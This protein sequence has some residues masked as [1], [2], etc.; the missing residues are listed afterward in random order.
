MSVPNLLWTSDKFVPVPDNLMEQ[1]V[2]KLNLM[3][4]CKRVHTNGGSAGI[5]GMKTDRL[6][7]WLQRNIE[8]LQNSLLEGSYQPQPVRAVGIEKPGGGKRILSIPTVVDRLIQQAI[9]QVLNPYFDPEFSSFSYGFR[10]GRSTKDAVLWVQKYQQEGK[11]WVIDVDLSKFFDEVN[12]DVLMSLIKRKVKDVRLLKLIDKY[13]RTGI[14]HG[15]VASP[16]SKG[17]PQGS[18]LSP[19]LSNILLNELDKEL[20]KRGHSFCRYADDFVIL[21]RSRKSA[22]R[23]FTSITRFIEKRLKLKINQTKSRVIKGYQLI[24]LG[25]GFTSDRN[26]RLTVPKSIRQRFRMKARELFRKGKGMNIQKFIV[27]ILNPFIRGWINYYKQSNVKG[28]AEELDGWI[29][30]RLRLII[31]RQWKKPRTRFRRFTT[32]GYKYVHA[33]KC[34]YNGRGAWWNSGAQHMQFCFPKKYFDR[35]GL[36]SMLYLIVR[37]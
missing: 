13:F 10:K 23:V 2:D 12:H 17:T 31:W 25:Y 11:R 33:M 15:G 7:S 20:E 21:V 37:N 36:V 1:I 24:Y 27:D 34:A 29:R 14:M 4:A 5:D 22:E 32:M 9:H 35:L 28:F 6:P 16:R 8:K 26:V 3:R 19:L 18:P 30:R